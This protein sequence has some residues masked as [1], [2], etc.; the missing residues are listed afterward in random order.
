MS[1]ILKVINFLIFKDFKKKR[2]Y[3]EFILIKNIKNQFLIAC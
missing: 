3:F 2:I 1:Y